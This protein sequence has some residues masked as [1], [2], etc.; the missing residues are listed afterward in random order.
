MCFTWLPAEGKGQ[1]ALR[2]QRLG[3]EALCQ[4]INVEVILSILVSDV[5]VGLHIQRFCFKL[6]YVNHGVLN[7][8]LHS[9]GKGPGKSDV[10]ATCS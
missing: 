6:V 5:V 9:T 10:S 8:K 1:G 4:G 3:N 2:A 7:L